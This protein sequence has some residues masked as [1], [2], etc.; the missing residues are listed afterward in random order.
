LWEP[1]RRFPIV[2]R[3]RGSR[4]VAPL[5]PP[6]R[7]H[8]QSYLRAKPGR[9]PPSPRGEIFLI[10]ML[11]CID[12]HCPAQSVQLSRSIAQTPSSFSSSPPLL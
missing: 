9:G 7:E 2:I 12:A 4:G 11:L 5:L 6:R 8:W 10:P 3:K 1:R